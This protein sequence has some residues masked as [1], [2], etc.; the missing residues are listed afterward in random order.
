MPI[1]EITN[2]CHIDSIE[3]I[4]KDGVKYPLI[5]TEIDMERCIVKLS[6]KKLLA[7][8]VEKVSLLDYHTQYTAH[9]IGK[10]NNDSVLIIDRMWIEG[11]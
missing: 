11:I 8:N 6:L 2:L 1:G 10:R 5:I 9:I 7:N 3:E 4:Y